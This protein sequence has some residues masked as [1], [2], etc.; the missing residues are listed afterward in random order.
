MC[1]YLHHLGISWCGWS[2][3]VWSASTPPTTPWMLSTNSWKSVST[4]CGLGKL[5]MAL[6]SWVGNGA[7]VGHWPMIWSM[8]TNML[9]CPTR[10]ATHHAVCAGVMLPMS[11]GTI[12]DLTLSGLGRFGQRRHGNWLVTIWKMVSF[13]LLGW[14]YCLS[15]PTGCTASLWALTSLWS[16]HINL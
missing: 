6:G 1:L 7:A 15:T 9:E 8:D 12:S 4:T 10:Q 5:K 3:P 2:T 14:Q 11:H 13:A 16:V